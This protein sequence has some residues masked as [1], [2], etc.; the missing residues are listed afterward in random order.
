MITRMKCQYCH[1]RHATHF[2]VPEEMWL[3]VIPEPQ[4]YGEV[5]LD[6]FIAEADEKLIRWCEAIT[7]TPMSLVKHFELSGFTPAYNYQE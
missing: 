3:A 7:I 5:C 2:H 1:K 6:C 4:C